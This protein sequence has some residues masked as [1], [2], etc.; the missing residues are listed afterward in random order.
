M[1]YAAKIGRFE[2]LKSKW[3][4]IVKCRFIIS[5]PPRLD[6]DALGYDSAHVD[7]PCRNLSILKYPQKRQRRCVMPHEGALCTV[8]VSEIHIEA[9]RKICGFA[10]IVMWRS[11]RWLGLRD[12]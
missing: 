10:F 2:W 8:V 6:L 9:E 4:R 12:I 11:I 7:H 1:W 3:S 5:S